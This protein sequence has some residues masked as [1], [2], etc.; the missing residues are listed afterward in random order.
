ML[1]QSREHGTPRG[2][3]LPEKTFLLADA[4]FV[5]FGLCL[6]PEIAFVGSQTLSQPRNPRAA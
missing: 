3:G 6:D 2:D 1:A 4:G 5:S